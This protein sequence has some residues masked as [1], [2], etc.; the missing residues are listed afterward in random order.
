MANV[1]LGQNILRN[2]SPFPPV[3]QRKVPPVVEKGLFEKIGQPALIIATLLAGL[4]S[5]RK[6]RQQAAI[7]IALAQ[8]LGLAGQG[9]RAE[10]ARVTETADID[11]QNL[12]AGYQGAVAQRG[13]EISLAKPYLTAAA[14]TTFAAP[15]VP[16]TPKS[17]DALMAR[18]IDN[19]ASLTPEMKE[20]T[21]IWWAK[22]FGEKPESPE[23]IRDLWSKATTIARIEFKIPDPKEYFMLKIADPTLPDYE[24]FLKDVNFYDEVQKNVFRMVQ[25]ERVFDS[26]EAQF[27]EGL[28]SDLEKRAKQNNRELEDEIKAL[29]VEDPETAQLIRN[30]LKFKEAGVGLQLQKADSRFN[31]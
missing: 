23:K 31:R 13:Q 3:P 17:V 12:L 19:Y 18:N 25:T 11:F 8:G 9:R 1:D 26:D 30:Y 14:R 5:K 24:T 29:E 21:D 15:K 27:M 20:R 28:V 22:K 7:P 2:L 4:S 10:Q 16:T 6:G